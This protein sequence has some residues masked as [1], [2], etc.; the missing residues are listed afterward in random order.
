[1]AIDRVPRADMLIGGTLALF[2]ASL[3]AACQPSGVGGSDRQSVVVPPASGTN[4]T[5]GTPAIPQEF[6]SDGIMPKRY[7]VVPY[8]YNYTDTYIDSFSVNGAG[9]G[10]LAVST[11]TAP[12]GGHTC[13]MTLVSGLPLDY[14]YVVKWTR[15][16]KRCS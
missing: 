9:G 8:G 16:R 1:M 3:L 11:P 12:G 10:N 14:E 13:C 2:T 4:K 7:S 6:E 15:D 5:A